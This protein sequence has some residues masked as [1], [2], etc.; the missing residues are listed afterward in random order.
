[1]GGQGG[2]LGLRCGLS[3]SLIIERR[4]SLAL[5]FYHRESGIGPAAL[6]ASSMTPLQIAVGAFRVG[7]AGFARR[8]ADVSVASPTLAS[9]LAAPDSLTKVRK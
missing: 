7:T 5:A 9:L 4:T 3:V 6:A 8:A 2:A 1:L